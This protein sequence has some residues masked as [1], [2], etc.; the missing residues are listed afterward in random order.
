VGTLEVVRPID[1]D[2]LFDGT[3]SSFSFEKPDDG[4]EY[5]VVLVSPSGKMF[6]VASTHDRAEADRVAANAN[7]TL[8]EVDWLRYEVRTVR[9]PGPRADEQLY[10]E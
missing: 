9:R 1:V 6:R 5:R 10:S 4:P 8:E 3:V 7:H 2:R